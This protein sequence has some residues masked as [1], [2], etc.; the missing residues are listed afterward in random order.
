MNNLLKISYVHDGTYLSDLFNR[1]LIGVF[2]VIF[3][4][5]RPERAPWTVAVLNIIVKSWNGNVSIVN[6]SYKANI[7]HNLPLPWLEVEIFI[8]ITNWNWN[9][10]DKWKMSSCQIMSHAY[11]LQ[12][13]QLWTT[14]LTLVSN[15]GS[16]FV[17]GIDGFWRRIS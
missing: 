3:P 16:H 12:T 2:F 9:W 6:N 7:A 1:F 11:V 10:P 5:R 13:I 14:R 17:M 15:P 8:I 4:M